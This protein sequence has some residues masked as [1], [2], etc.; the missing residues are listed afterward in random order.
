V[1]AC[2][3]RGLTSQESLCNLAIDCQLLA[4]ESKCKLLNI[5]NKTR[6]YDLPSQRRAVNIL[7]LMS[8]QPHCLYRLWTM[9]AG[10]G[11]PILLDVFSQLFKV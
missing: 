1:F 5:L 4:G 6:E 10:P 9:I 11:S 3:S 2:A 7:T 8:D